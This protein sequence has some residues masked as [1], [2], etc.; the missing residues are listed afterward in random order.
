MF[1]LYRGLFAYFFSDGLNMEICAE[2]E[3]HV[4]LFRFY[5]PLGLVSVT[6]VCVTAYFETSHHFTLH[7]DSACQGF[8]Q[9]TQWFLVF[10]L[11]DAWG[12]SR[13]D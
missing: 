9:G 6:A 2:G 12:L 1:W 7:T 4:A 11:S 13:K 10:L 3:F 8:T 5:F